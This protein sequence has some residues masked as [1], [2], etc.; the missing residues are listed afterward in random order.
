MNSFKMT[1]QPVT[2]FYATPF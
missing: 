1:L 2:N